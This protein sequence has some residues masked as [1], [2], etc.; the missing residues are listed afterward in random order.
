MGP[1][2]TGIEPL[3]VPAKPAAGADAST[4]SK[5]PY[6]VSGTGFESICA[7]DKSQVLQC[8]SLVDASTGNATS[9][10][11]HH[12][13]VLNDQAARL[14]LDND[15]KPHLLLHWTNKE[16]QNTEWSLTTKATA[17]AATTITADKSLKKGDSL[18]VVFN[19]K[20]FSG[21]SVVSFEDTTLTI[22]AKDTK[23]I[24]VLVTTKVT[25]SPGS[26]DLIATG[27]DGKPIV[28]PVIITAP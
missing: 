2:F 10:K 1:T 23:S 3:I 6:E 11:S 20:D 14:V 24:T 9:L 15:T 26:K 7:P 19:G 25:A 5:G 21:V 22:L 16:G 13:Q 28:L 17:P 4:L 18:S 27:A 8:L 12:F